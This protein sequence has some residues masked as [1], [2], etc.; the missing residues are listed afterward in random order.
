VTEPIRSPNI[1]ESPEVYELENLGVD[2]AGA[3]EAAMR[4]V[5]DWA[6]RDARAPGGDP[7]LL[8]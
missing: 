6:G 3:I 8:E 5:Q 7:S 2:R 4:D 1:W